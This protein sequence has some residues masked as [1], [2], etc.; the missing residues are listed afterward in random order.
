MRVG[1]HAVTVLAMTLCFAVGAGAA[2]EGFTPLFNGK[3]LSGWAGDMTR[4]KVE[5]G[6]ITGYTTPDN[7]LKYNTFL[8]WQGGKPADFDLRFTYRIIGGNSGV[9]YRSQ[10]IDPEKWVIK[11]YQGDIDS[12]PKYTGMNYEERGRKFLAER[13][14]RSVIDAQGQKKSETF[15][16][17]D[18]LQKKIRGEDWN[19]YRIVAKG[20][21]LQHYV[22]GELMS[23]VTDNGPEAAKDGV[24][25]I[26]VHQGPPMKIQVK[27]IRIMEMK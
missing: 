21:K 8:V 14:Q 22:N 1:F 16:D 17:K 18:E 20:N 5:D 25:A 12:S 10:V 2:E 9:Q 24:I 15:A 11:G 19:E 26:Q 13:G 23:E 3:D 27:D 4:W 7:L 6:A